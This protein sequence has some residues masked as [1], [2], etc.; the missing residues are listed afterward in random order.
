MLLLNVLGK[1]NRFLFWEN[2][3]FTLFDHYTSHFKCVF[4]EWGN[5]PTVYTHPSQPKLLLYYSFTSEQWNKG[6]LCKTHKKEWEKL[7]KLKEEMIDC[8][9]NPC[10]MFW[11]IFK[12]LIW[13]L[14]STVKYLVFLSRSLCLWWNCKVD[15]EITR[16]KQAGSS[17]CCDFWWITHIITLILF[18]FIHFY[19]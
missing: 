5:S 10:S 2:I 17:S 11:W 12:Y 7:N 6:G 15:E 18:L 8:S 3:C 19:V 13:V 4:V 1:I 16:I 14:I 9:K